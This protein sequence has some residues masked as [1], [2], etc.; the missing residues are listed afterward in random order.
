MQPA[1]FDD[2]MRALGD[3]AI[4]DN[5]ANEDFREE[6]AASSWLCSSG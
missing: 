3:H 5:S 4:R 1:K 6:M 2:G